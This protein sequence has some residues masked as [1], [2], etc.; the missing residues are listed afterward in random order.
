MRQPHM[1]DRMLSWGGPSSRWLRAHAQCDS[2]SLSLASRHALSTGSSR[3]SGSSDDAGRG[4]PS[5]ML[6]MLHVEML[7]SEL[8]DEEEEEE[9]EEEG[10]EGAGGGAAADVDTASAERRSSPKVARSSPDVAVASPAAPAASPAAASCGGAGTPGAS[11]SS[12]R[13]CGGDANGW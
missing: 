10:G 4:W 3:P 9:E 1:T 12:R 6:Q 2:T 7:S 5:H 13:T 11:S 8:A